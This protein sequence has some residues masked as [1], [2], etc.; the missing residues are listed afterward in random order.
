MD[1]ESTIRHAILSAE[2]KARA[3]IGGAEPEQEV[4]D[5]LRRA[6]ETDTDAPW[7]SLRKQLNPS[8]SRR[9][10]W[11]VVAAAAAVVIAAGITFTLMSRTAEPRRPQYALFDGSRAAPG[12]K[13]G[14]IIIGGSEFSIPE[15]T[16]MEV[17][18]EGVTFASTHNDGRRVRL[19]AD[20]GN[21]T[22]RTP[23]GGKAGFTTADGTEISLNADTKVSL[24]ATA[25]GSERRIS[26]QGE[27][28]LHVAHNEERPFYVSIG[29]LQ[30]HVTGTVFNVSAR[31]GR[32]VSVTLTDGSVRIERKDGSLVATLKPGEQFTSS[33][34]GTGFSVSRADTDA[35]LA[36]TRGQFVFR[37]EPLADIMHDISLWY[38]VDF[39]VPKSLA[40]R[41]YSGEL[42][43]TE[44]LE[45]LLK[46]LRLTGEMEF[47]DHGNHKVEIVDKKKQ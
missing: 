16:Q 40:G 27:A 41:R 5:S 3:V 17:D 29:A 7:R 19:M 39:T 2:E 4:T 38:D 46:V 37:D 25:A 21:I 24:N 23:R 11:T 43:R 8:R 1:I 36:W 47:I 35:A 28:C 9:R 31:P 32:P 14:N 42:S 45:P 26:L 6:A 13:G 18:S 10:L 33:A 15:G 34:D 44:T 20:G 22:V 12:N 30:V